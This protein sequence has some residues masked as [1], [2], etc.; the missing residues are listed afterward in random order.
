M[1]RGSYS[2]SQEVQ[3][4]VPSQITPQLTNHAELQ[5]TQFMIETTEKWHAATDP[6]YKRMLKDGIDTMR[7]NLRLPPLPDVDSTT[8]DGEDEADDGD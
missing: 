2:A 1:A 3:S 5:M 6:M 4:E 8:G 7:R